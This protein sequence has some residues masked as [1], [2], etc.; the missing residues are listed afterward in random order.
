M[1]ISIGAL[2]PALLLAPSK[3][4]AAPVPAKLVTSPAGVIFLI[5]LFPKSATYT[6]PALSTLNPDGVLN[7]AIVPLPSRYP[8]VVPPASVEITP[9]L[10]IFQMR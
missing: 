8:E 7:F 1:A 3:E 9:V 10:L 5:L 4:V 6:L 2:K